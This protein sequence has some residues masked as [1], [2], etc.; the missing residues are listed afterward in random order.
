M[1]G[2]IVGRGSPVAAEVTLRIRAE[3]AEALARINQFAKGVQD[4]FA[5]IK[6]SDPVLAAASAKVEQFTRTV[7]RQGQAV[8]G[9]AGRFREYEPAGAFLEK[10][11]R[12]AEDAGRRAGAA[13]PG[14]EG[15][16]RHAAVLAST[17]PGSSAVLGELVGVLQGAPPQLALMAVALGVV[18]SSFVKLQAATLDYRHV[19]S[20]TIIELGTLRGTFVARQ[21]QLD[22]EQG[23]SLAQLQGREIEALR[24]RQEALK[25]AAA[26]ELATIEGTR[27]TRLQA[28]VE[29]FEAEKS[30]MDTVALRA[31]LESKT[32]L[33]I[34]TADAQ[35]ALARKTRQRELAAAL[36]RITT[37]FAIQS[38]AA[39]RAGEM[40]R[41]RL[42]EDIA[43]KIARARAGAALGTL[44]VRA[45]VS[46]NPL[47]GIQADLERQRQGIL[48]AFG[49]QVKAQEAALDQGKILDTEFFA[50]RRALADAATQH[51]TNALALAAEAQKAAVAEIGSASAQ[52]FARLGPGFEDLQQKLALKDVVTQSAK[53]FQVLANAFDTGDARA[54]E[55]AE[56]VR[57][58]TEDLLAQGATI[59]Q[60]ET[61]VPKT[62]Q[63]ITSLF[64]DSSTTVATLEGETK[65]VQSAMNALTAQPLVVLTGG[66][67]DAEAAA[68]R[69]RLKVLEIVRAST[70]IPRIGQTL[71][72]GQTPEGSPGE[73]PAEARRAFARALDD[74][75]RRGLIS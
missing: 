14:V 12:S 32:T 36:L 64:R 75:R 50:N 47:E 17:V 21:K 52:L 13:G 45:R 16:S 1:A 58:M 73:I 4:S 28:A 57:R 70:F 34:D 39:H 69:Y 2:R 38:A 74:D 9:A 68:E 53:D 29:R 66:W 3:S 18:T 43:E 46:G 55:A 63:N 15:L 10:F 65:D 71:P 31:V 22:A 35:A 23:A 8:Q 56:A 24:F 41:L 37:E 27:R 44:D 67:N 51:W 25:A 19:A 7:Q 5:A 40:E 72:P 49:D 30:W 60:I 61:V 20:R 48:Q 59:K 6:A 11:G 42:T 33:E 54:T 26:V 62:L